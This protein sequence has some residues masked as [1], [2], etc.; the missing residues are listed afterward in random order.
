LQA[1]VDAAVERIKAHPG[2]F[3]RH[4]EQGVRKIHLKR[5]PY[6]IYYLE[7]D[8]IIWIAAVA[9]QKRKRDYWAMR[10]PHE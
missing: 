2:R 8:D 10:E 9:H 1:K 7:L 6:S 3:A 4:N 5:F